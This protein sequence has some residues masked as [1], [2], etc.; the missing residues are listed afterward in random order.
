ML[1]NFNKVMYIITSY[2]YNDNYINM[3]ID[4]ITKVDFILLKTIIEHLRLT[5]QQINDIIIQVIINKQNNNIIELLLKT[6][7]DFYCDDLCLRTAIVVDNVE[8]VK[9]I[10]Q[11]KNFNSTHINDMIV[12][13]SIN[14]VKYMLQNYDNNTIFYNKHL[15]KSSK[16]MIQ[17]LLD[18][19]KIN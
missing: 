15:K 5:F 8:A 9:M 1:Y 13:N 7:K 12:Y 19:M 3:I 2:L 6:Y 14:V 11:D 10:I 18:F 16:E 17:L 4:C